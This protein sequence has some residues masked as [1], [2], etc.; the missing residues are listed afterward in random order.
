M[1]KPDVTTTEVVIMYL[2]M[3]VFLFGMVIAVMKKG[4]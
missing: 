2:G 4:S 1:L 3:F